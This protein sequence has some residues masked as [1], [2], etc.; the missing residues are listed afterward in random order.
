LNNEVWLPVELVAVESVHAYALGLAFSRLASVVVEVCVAFAIIKL[1]VLKPL[2]VVVGLHVAFV[3]PKP[4][5]GSLFGVDVVLRLG[6]AAER[7]E[8]HD[9][10][11]LIAGLYVFVVPHNKPDA[12]RGF[13]D[14]RA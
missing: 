1:A 5:I 11:G 3:K 14:S 6:V 8:Q 4:L 12:E 7:L 13:V 9:V 2:G 10:F